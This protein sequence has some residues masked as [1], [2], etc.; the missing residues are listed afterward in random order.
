MK[1]EIPRPMKVEHDE[2]HA[3]LVEATKVTAL[4]PR[5]CVGRVLENRSELDLHQ[6]RSVASG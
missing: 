4:L 6:T 1:L 5:P 2:L 3:D